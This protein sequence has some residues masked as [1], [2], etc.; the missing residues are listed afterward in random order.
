M[1]RQHPRTHTNAG[2]TPEPTADGPGMT[3]VTARRLL[4]EVGAVHQPNARPVTDRQAAMAAPWEDPIPLTP[5]RVLPPFPVGVFPPW[6][7]AMVTETST[8]LQVPPD[9]PATLALACLA[10]AAGGRVDIQARPG[11]VEPTNLYTVVALAPGSRKSSTFSMMTRPLYLAEQALADTTET[12]RMEAALLARRAHAAAE[13]AAK[14]A[15]NTD[16]DAPM[17][18]AV[19]AAETASRYA[20][21]IHEPRLLADDLTPETAAT[22]LARHG[23]RL[24]L[25]SAEGGAFTTVS[26]ARYNAAKGANLEPLLKAHSGDMIRVDRQGRPAEKIDRP[27]L[28]IALTTQPGHLAGIA[29]DPEARARGLLARFLYSIPTNTV[30]TRTINPP[31]VTDATSNTYDA[32]LTTLVAGLHTLPDRATLTCTP[33]AAHI[34]LELE[35]WLEPRLHPDT[36]TLAPVTDWASKMAGLATR[37][38]ALLHLAAHTN[39]TTHGTEQ[40][41][42]ADTMTA[43]VQVAHYYLSHALG[44]FTTLTLPPELDTARHLLDWATR[45]RADT[46]T[47]RDAYRALTSTRFPTAADL[48]P[49]LAVLLDHGYLRELPPARTGGPG[50]TPSPTY[51]LHPH[52]HPR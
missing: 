47:R 1:T 32:H 3:P 33:D 41:V 9:L 38:A 16:D 42:T 27:A 30:G 44:V 28:T 29:A 14:A 2:P 50:R 19:A 18:D 52:H 34:L 10:V 40:P 13:R 8:A 11:W 45:T 31:P 49:P 17:A 36:G 24:A 26:G 46:F 23:G 22:L 15:E 6:L 48:D 37:T 20:G 21:D 7:A 25:L 5:A 39:S 43:A 12:A 4:A 51:Q 35:E